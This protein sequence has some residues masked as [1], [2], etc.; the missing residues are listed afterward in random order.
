MISWICKKQASVAQS[1]IEAEYIAA[2][3]GAREGV[4]LRKLLSD[5]FCEPMK[6]TT[7]HCDNQSC[8]KLFVNPVFHD[9]SKLIEILYHYVRDMVEKKVIQLEYINTGDQTIDILTKAL[10]KVKVDHFR[11]KLGMV[12]M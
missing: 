4:W 12:E 6:P 7:I 5:L 1:S 11:K 3:M 9:R 2:A 10:P 8:I